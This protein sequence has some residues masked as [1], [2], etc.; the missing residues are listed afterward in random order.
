MAKYIDADK[1]IKD[2]TDIFTEYGIEL[3]EQF[4]G[5]INQSPAENVAP[6]E[7]AEWIEKVKPCEWSEDDV[8]ISYKCSHCNNIFDYVSNYCPNCGSKMKEGLRRE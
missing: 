5:V 3:A 1:L 4:Q 8:E 7:S 6:R 2:Y